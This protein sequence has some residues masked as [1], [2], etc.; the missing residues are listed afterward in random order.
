MGEISDCNSHARGGACSRGAD[1]GCEALPKPVK[2]T[3]RI[4]NLGDR[5]RD[6]F[7][8]QIDEHDDGV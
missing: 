6:T 4:G 8:D 5:L 7:G 2:E 3:D 1:L